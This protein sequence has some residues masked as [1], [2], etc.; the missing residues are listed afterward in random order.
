MSLLGLG[1]ASTK[2][3][4][5]REKDENDDEDDFHVSDPMQ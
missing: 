5:R 3:E 4:T 2:K 1:P